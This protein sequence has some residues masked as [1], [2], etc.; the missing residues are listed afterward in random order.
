MHLAYFSFTYK[1]QTHSPTEENTEVLP[2]IFWEEC[3][4]TPMSENALSHC[5]CYWSVMEAL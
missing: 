1:S 5:M 3:I 2:K 4:S